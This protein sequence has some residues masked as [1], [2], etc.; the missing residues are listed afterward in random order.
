[1]E[2]GVMASKRSYPCGAEKRKKMK[3]EEERQLKDKG[4]ALFVMWGGWGE[5]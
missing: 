1:M 5:V 2:N 4:K 3:I